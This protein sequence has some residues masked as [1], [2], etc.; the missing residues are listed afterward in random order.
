LVINF[1]H[2]FWPSLVRHDGF[3]K[4]FITP[5]IKVF[6]KSAGATSEALQTFFTLPEYEAWSRTQNNMGIYRV[7]YYKGLGTSTSKEAKEYFS[8]IGQHKIE[9]DYID[10]NDDEAIDMA[11][12]KKK[13]D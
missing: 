12:N 8:S 11:F 13:A 9:F 3:L 10:H 1:F 6:R 4:E 7:K 2:H 5:I